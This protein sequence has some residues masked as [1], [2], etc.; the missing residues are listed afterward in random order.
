MITEAFEQELMAAARSR[1]AF[2]PGAYY[3]KDGDCIE[4]FVSDE[5]SHAERIDQLVTVYYG[6]ETGEIT[7][8][9]VKGVKQY[10]DG[11][12]RRNPLFKVAIKDGR[13]KLE[14]LFISRL[15]T[16]NADDVELV[17]LQYEKLLR[18]AEKTDAVAEIEG[19]FA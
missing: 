8:A 12:L 9:L 16:P 17:T 1:E 2:Q 19:V 4:F 7:G 3:D 18:L 13:I 5:M 15:L 11:V 10:L 6:D 14:Y